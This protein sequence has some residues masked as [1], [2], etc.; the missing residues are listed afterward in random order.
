MQNKNEVKHLILF[1]VI[2]FGLCWIPIF[3]LYSAI[4]YK[5]WFNHVITATKFAPAFACILVRIISN[6]KRDFYK[7]HL[8]LN[9]N[10]RYYV[11]SFILPLFF[12]ITLALF[13]NLLYGHWDTEEFKSHGTFISNMAQILNIYILPIFFSVF[14]CLGEEIGWR[15]YM[16]QKLEKKFGIYGTCIIG[17][18][19]W[20]IWYLPLIVNGY[21]LG[22]DYS[23]FPFL[24]VLVV[25][26]SCIFLQ[27]IFMWLTKM[28]NSIYPAAIMHS[29]LYLRMYEVGFIFVCGVP[30]EQQMK[31][32]FLKVISILLIPE[33]LIGMLCIANMVKKE[34]NN[35]GK[36]ESLSN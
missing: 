1:F 16:N 14:I 21:Q 3:V 31:I 27:A 4:G 30:I 2:S 9:N 22:K 13:I 26:L 33:A 6:E 34:K 5:V 12:G 29:L 8:N 15:D 7:L 25:I 23:Y 35:I 24:G 19:I 10:L 20:G 32:D 36:N 17:G 11:F 28:T 18:I